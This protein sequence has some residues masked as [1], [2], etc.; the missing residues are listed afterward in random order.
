MEIAQ[1]IDSALYEYYSER[2]MNV[3]K[4][5]RT[6]PQW[7]VDYLTSLGIDPSNP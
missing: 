6:H 5:K 3:P 7:W 4:W 1:I 2:G